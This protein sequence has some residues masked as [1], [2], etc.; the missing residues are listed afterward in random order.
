MTH[1]EEGS[2]LENLWVSNTIILLREKFIDS[3]RRETS[4]ALKPLV[5]F[6]HNTC[7]L[8]NFYGYLCFYLIFGTFIVFNVEMEMKVDVSG[9]NWIGCILGNWTLFL[10]LIATLWAK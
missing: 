8:H 1:R 4:E 2:H 9:A 7:N 6:Y 10:K 5:L 3:H